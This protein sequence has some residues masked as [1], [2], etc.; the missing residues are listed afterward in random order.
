MNEAAA[1]IR[2]LWL[3]YIALLAY[4]FGAVSTVTHRDLLLENPI[5]LPVL[6]VELP[7]VGFLFA[8]PIFLLINHFYLLLQLFG[9]GC[10][11]REFNEEIAKTGLGEAAE[12][13][14]RRRLDTFV[15]VQMLGGTKEERVGLTGK[16]LKAIALITLV[17]APIVLLLTIQFQFLPYQDE[18]ITWIHRF[19][20]SV[21]LA[22]LWIFWSSIRL[23][24]WAPLWGPVRPMA[25]LA[26]VPISYVVATFPGE[27]VDGGGNG[28][29]LEEIRR[30]LYGTTEGYDF[31]QRPVFQITRSFRGRNTY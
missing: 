4:L 7:L 19:A 8:A 6:N 9:L 17:V 24:N 3:S 12:R 31:R 13:P 14:E 21:D 16:F 23:G 20:L 5:K 11:I 28:K 27:F 15:I 10:R 30:Q 25:V 18:L 26:I 22:L 2:G 1:R 29:R